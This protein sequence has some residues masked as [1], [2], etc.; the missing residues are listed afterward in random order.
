MDFLPPLTAF[1]EAGFILFV[2][3]GALA[4]LN[5]IRI[6]IR[7]RWFTK[8]DFW[9]DKITGKWRGIVKPGVRSLLLSFSNWR[10][11][12]CGQKNLAQLETRVYDVLSGGVTNPAKLNADN[13]RDYLCGAC[14]CV[15]NASL[16]ETEVKVL[17]EDTDPIRELRRP[18]THGK[19]FIVGGLGVENRINVCKTCDGEKLVKVPQGNHSA[20]MVDARCPDCYNPDDW[21][22]PPTMTAR[23]RAIEHTRAKVSSEEADRLK[24]PREDIIS[25]M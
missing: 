24:E 19:A 12:C 13:T 8:T 23:R 22:A 4:A 7:Y 18:A 10:C 17:R 15:Y 9:G 2:I 3:V 25:Q 11:N 16:H 5:G 20:A 21:E 6:S 14:G 1:I